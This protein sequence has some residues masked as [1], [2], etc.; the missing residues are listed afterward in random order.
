MSGA[1]WHPIR[2]RRALIREVEASLAEERESTER[3]VEATEKLS[4]ASDR[5]D[6]VISGLQPPDES[7]TSGPDSDVST[8]ETV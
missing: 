4:A 6:Q 2:E 5:A 8:E 1:G 3:L 7:S